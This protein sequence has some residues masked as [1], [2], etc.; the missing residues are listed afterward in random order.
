MAAAPPLHVEPVFIKRRDLP[1]FNSAPSD[2]TTALDICLS[3]EVVSGRETVY[4]AQEIKGLW[5]IYP[6]SREARNKLLIEGITVQGVSVN[7]HDKNPY[8]LRDSGNEIP[9]TKLFIS[10]IPISLSDRDIETALVRI[11]CV[12]RSSLILEK[13]R[14][15]DGKLTRFV[16]GRRFCFINLPA[17]SL[18]PSLQVG[19][20]VG[21]LYY[22]EQDKPSRRRLVCSKCLQEGHHV[23]VCQNDV[24]C[25]QCGQSGHVRG[26]DACAV[27]REKS[28]IAINLFGSAEASPDGAEGGESEVEGESGDEL[29]DREDQSAQQRGIPVHVFHTPPTK[30]RDTNQRGRG[31][32]LQT[33]LTAASRSRD[34]T[35]KRLRPP[36]GDSPGSGKDTKRANKSKADEKKRDNAG[37]STRDSAVK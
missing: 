2:Q 23:S 7:L 35:P 6:L 31:T 18:D 3:A 1:T 8:I 13:I 21:R 9:A 10:D 19:S 30:P 33:K 34:V 22:K 27:F 25:R 14:N 36:S 37:G 16:T 15:K 4:G 26:D 17:K 32:L 28:P 11:G 20:F 5:R 29:A 12:L 24:T